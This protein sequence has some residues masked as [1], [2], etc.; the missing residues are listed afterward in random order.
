MYSNGV[1]L[2]NKLRNKIRVY[3]ELIILIVML[4]SVFHFFL[5]SSLVPRTRKRDYI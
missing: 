5:R 3:I 1:G 2:I 4:H